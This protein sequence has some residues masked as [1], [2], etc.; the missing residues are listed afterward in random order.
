MTDDL[1]FDY[2]RDEIFEGAT[3]VGDMRF[4]LIFEG[5]AENLTPGTHTFRSRKMA[6]AFAGLMLS[7]GEADR[8]LLRC[9]VAD[10]VSTESAPAV[11]WDLLRSE[12]LTHGVDDLGRG[13]VNKVTLWEARGE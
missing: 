11:V 1:D 3:L 10:Y 8:A 2:I 7:M 5:A 9:Y 12:G 6:E 13:R 4:E